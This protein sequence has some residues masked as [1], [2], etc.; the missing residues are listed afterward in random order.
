MTTTHLTHS[1]RSSI[2]SRHSRHRRT[3]AAA[4][5]MD[6]MTEAGFDAAVASY[7]PWLQK[8]PEELEKQKTVHAVLRKKAGAIIG[9]GCYVSPEARVLTQRFVLGAGSWVAGGAIIRGNVEIGTDCS[10]NSYAH[11]A[12]NVKIGNGCRIASLVSIYGFDHGIA[13]IDQP[14]K[15]QKLTSRGVKLH[16][17]IWV[18]ANVV[19]LDGVEIGS[20]CVVAAGSVV[21][22][23]FPAYKIIGGNPAK[24]LRDRTETV[25][26]LQNRRPMPS[27][28]PPQRTSRANASVICFLPT[29]PYANLETRF[30]RDLQGWDSDNPLFKQVISDIRPALIVEV[31]TW[32]GA[33]AIHMAGICRQLGLD[34]EI[35]CIDTWL[36]NWQHWARRDGVGSRVDLRLKNGLPHLYYQFMSN[37]LIERMDDIITPLPLTGIAGAELFA[38]YELRPDIV[39]VDGDHE[40]EAVISD[41]RGWLARLSDRGVLIGD[42]YMWPGVERAVR[43]I[44]TEQEWAANV[45]GNKF[46][47]RR[48]RR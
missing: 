31:G 38:H 21:T 34:A 27:L 1:A 3:R 39:Y 2:F 28:Q 44:T 30:P 9:A 46:V 36:G 8:T 40:Y 12:G 48:D 10:V 41:L 15:D 43:E 37:V 29:I 35:V 33:S 14:I 20:H 11:I 6:N 5:R 23:S 17:D 42:D 7:Q 13:R 19:I 18:G 22:K 25:R 4:K 16:H 47:I 26:H 45:T 24:I 32:K